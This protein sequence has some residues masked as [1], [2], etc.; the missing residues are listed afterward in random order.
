MRMENIVFEK[1]SLRGKTTEQALAALDRW[2]S[3]T[4]DK[5]NYLQDEAGKDGKQ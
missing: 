4:V 5:L 2:I 3:D 1:L